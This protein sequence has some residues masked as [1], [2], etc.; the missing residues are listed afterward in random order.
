MVR[1]VRF[2]LDLAVGERERNVVSG[3]LQQFVYFS[4]WRRTAFLTPGASE[5]LAEAVNSY[6]SASNLFSCW[7]RTRQSSTNSGQRS[8]TSGR[9]RE[10][11]LFECD[12]YS[13]S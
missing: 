8:C 4:I 10:L 3:K 13:S 6:L 12:G 11:K 5:V 1:S 9:A 7:T 2:P